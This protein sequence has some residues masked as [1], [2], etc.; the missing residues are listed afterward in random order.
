M[1]T[2]NKHLSPEA[3]KE[4][5]EKFAL[6]AL[7]ELSQFRTKQKCRCSELAI[8]IAHDHPT[9]G[10]ARSTVFETDKES[11]DAYLDVLYDITD[12]FEDLTHLPKKERLARLKALQTATNANYVKVNGKYVT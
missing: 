11:L 3:K 10:S 4:L 6:E 12:I 1:K 5:E 2:N 9:S 8:T 7:E